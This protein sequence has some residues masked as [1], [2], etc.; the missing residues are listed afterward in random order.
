MDRES[1]RIQDIDE[2]R[3]AARILEM[4]EPYTDDIRGRLHEEF[5]QC[6]SDDTLELQSI[7]H[8]LAALNAILSDIENV[9]LT[10]Q[11]AEQEQLQ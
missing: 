7:S 3:R 1:D 2:G 6:K 11:M 5:E 10:G 8:R 4:I 9:K